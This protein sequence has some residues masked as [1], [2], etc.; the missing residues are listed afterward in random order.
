MNR[1]PLTA[2]IAALIILLATFLI[3][4]AA[5][6]IPETGESEIINRGVLQVVQF[7]VSPRLVDIQ[8]PEM[9]VRSFLEV[10]D[11]LD[12]G[13]EGLASGP[14]DVDGAVQ[15]AV[16]GSSMPS[17]LI[18]FKGP[19]NTYNIAPP[20]P[21]GDVGTDHVVMMSNLSLAVYSKTGALLYGPVANNTIWAGFGGA[22][23]TSNDG[24]PIVLYDQLADRWLIT[25]FTSGGPTYYECV[26]LS[27]TGDPTGSYYRWAVNT[28]S[29]FP[30]Y[31]K[32][33][34]WSDGY[35][36]S[37]REFSGVGFDGIGAY[38]MNK[39]QMLAGNASPTII[40]FLVTPG[41]EPWKA[42]D[43]LLPA[44]LDGDTLPP[45][46]N[47][48]YFVGSMDNGSWTGAPSDGLNL[49]HFTPDW[50][51]PVNSTFVLDA[52]LP[53]ATFD[54][55]F[56]CGSGRECIPQ[57]GTSNN[58]DIL[59]YR[60]RPMFRLAYRNF[61]TH[62]SLVTNQS[63]NVNN[64]TAGIRWWEIRDPN[65]TPAVYQ[66][67]T[68]A[69]G[70]SD[71]VH[72]WMGSIAMDSLGN[73]ALGFSASSASIY[74]SI[75]YTG[76]LAS[77]SLG[78]MP[79]GE[80]VIVNGTGAQTSSQRW[81]DYTSMVVDPVDDCT[82]WYT[83]QWLPANGLNWELRIGAFR[84]DG[85]GAEIEVTPLQGGA[86]LEPDNTIT[87]TV[88]ISNTGVYT[89][90][91]S[92]EEDYL[93]HPLVAP[94]L[95]AVLTAG[96]DAPTDDASNDSAFPAA[97]PHAITGPA[98]WSWPTTGVIYDNGPLV[99][100]AGCGTV[101]EDLSILES[102]TLSASTYGFGH[103]APIGLW[104]ADD[105]T[106]SHP[107]G[108]TLDKVTL[109]A[110]QTNS[111]TI[112]T[113]EGVNWYLYNGM[114]GTGG[115]PIA[116]GS[117]FWETGWTN[118]FRVEEFD[119][120]DVSRPIMYSDVSL[121]SQYL[122][123]G[124]Y[125][126]V[127]QAH[128]SLASG[129]WAP[130]IAILGQ[131]TTGNGLQSL[132]NLATFQP[133]LDTGT[134]T[135][136]GFPFVLHGVVGQLGCASPEDIPWISLGSTSGAIAGGSATDVSVVFDSTG[137]TAGKYEGSLCI[138]SNDQDESLVIVDLVMFVYKNPRFLPVISKP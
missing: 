123:P 38:A 46:G 25:Q 44:D 54:T 113:I 126:L 97:A 110:Y 125:W 51:T 12:T 15:A 10:L 122:A 132:D 89:L 37:T 137:L 21:N 90:N 134:S 80:G 8:P 105:F 115:T 9:D 17:P 33:G 5:S 94:P 117:G 20:D 35:Y 4:G 101:G 50:S 23:E 43:G 34:V 96:P 68:Y 100:C 87:R 66:E 40:S 52:T 22:C 60:Q 57:K 91:W 119:E 106:V 6:E 83:N 109:F 108:W 14:Q 79:Q 45:A 64:G 65:G 78:I 75:W 62:E 69:P 74:P 42:G 76:R 128:G 116:S 93:D 55:I 85:C 67:G 133:A 77:D 71:G 31:P 73:M 28:G 29:N 49:W 39:S 30:D 92:I 24:D 131:D 32:F 27:T 102:F 135:Q 47:P 53:I 111:L 63:V 88:T 3:G 7:D 58:V 82:F 16:G 86:I 81:G 121:G 56:P 129:P 124:T 13:M 48:H 84:F 26:A 103:Q 136:Q 2:L 130:P 95:P 41:S 104:V 118:V 112:S 36:F 59:S 72:R 11:D 98:P 120:T 99:N 138:S 19:S 18:T 70:V 61:G 1:K 107:E 127:W 114:P